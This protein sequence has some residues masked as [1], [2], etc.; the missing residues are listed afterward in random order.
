MKIGFWGALCQSGVGYV[1]K[2]LVEGLEIQIV[3]IVPNMH[4]GFRLDWVKGRDYTLLNMPIYTQGEIED[5]LDRAKPDVVIV[6]ETPYT[7]Y[8]GLECKKRGIKTVNVAMWE[9]T[10]NRLL[11]DFDYHVAKFPWE[12]KHL[13]E[14]MGY[15]VLDLILPVEIHNFKFKKRSGKP[16]NWLHV[17][18]Y[19]G[20][21]GRKNVELTI[22]AFSKSNAYGLLFVKSQVE[23][24]VYSQKFCSRKSSLFELTRE[25]KDDRIII[26]VGNNKGENYELYPDEADVAIQPSRI[27]GYGLNIVEPLMTGMPVITTDAEPMSCWS[28]SPYLTKCNY[29]TI[30]RIRQDG[31]FGRNIHTGVRYAN[32]KENDLVAKINEIAERD[33]GKD[34]EKARAKMEKMSWEKQRDNWIDVLEKVI[35]E[36]A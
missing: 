2:N 11:K 3:A 5:W 16:K 14:V 25:L 10:D 1:G 9:G 22:R 8:L 35:A 27:E 36:K 4:K 33:I 29:E 6:V 32:V 34:S 19:G 20:F 31:T 26:Q 13:V 15:K 12:R 24:S 23:E 28:F 7:Q 30:V 18:G 17:A 21:W